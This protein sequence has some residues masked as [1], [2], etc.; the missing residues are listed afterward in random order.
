MCLCN[1]PFAVMKYNNRNTI[2]SLLVLLPFLVL[3]AIVPKNASLEI[4]HSAMK[5][6]LKTQSAVLCYSSLAVIPLQ[7]VQELF[8][9]HRS[10][11]S[12]SS[13]SKNEDKKTT[14]S[15]N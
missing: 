11:E 5:E 10:S 12:A 4:G 3:N 15:S 6:L 2:P 8:N 9:Q 7:L 1:P 14:N 13:K